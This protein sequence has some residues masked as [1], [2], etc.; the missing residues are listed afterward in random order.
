M[1]IIVMVE[2]FTCIEENRGICRMNATIYSHI[3][4]RERGREREGERE[5]KG[6]LGEVKKP[7][8]IEGCL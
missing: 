5:D 4:S 3:Y 6:R 1:V 8:K 7:R 2:R